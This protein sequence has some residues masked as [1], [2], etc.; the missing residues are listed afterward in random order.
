MTS[1]K[2]WI[3]PPTSLAPSTPNMVACSLN[4]GFIKVLSAFAP[5]SLYW[6]S[7]STIALYSWT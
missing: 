7:T 4:A 1:Y 6:L 3:A 5:P 2:F